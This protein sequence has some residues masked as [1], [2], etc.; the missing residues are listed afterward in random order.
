MQNLT[1][2]NS[3]GVKRI[4]KEGNFINHATK[5]RYGILIDNKYLVAHVKP[6]HAMHSLKKFT[7]KATEFVRIKW[8]KVER[9]K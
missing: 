8:Q 5:P 6:I 7:G 2:L 1:V 9:N 4:V 3:K